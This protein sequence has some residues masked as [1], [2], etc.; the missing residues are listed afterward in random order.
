MIRKHVLVLFAVGAML[1][2]A[3]LEY[4]IAQK[5]RPNWSIKDVTARFKADID[6]R[7]FFGGGTLKPKPDSRILEIYGTF[8]ATTEPRSVAL[9]G[10]F[11]SPGSTPKI[12]K[13]RWGIESMGAYLG[14]ICNHHFV[15]PLL[16]G[17]VKVSFGGEEKFV[18]FASKI[19][20]VGAVKWAVGK[21]TEK[22]PWQ[23]KFYQNPTPLCMAFVVP[24]D[25]L[26]IKSVT[27]H[28]GDATVPVVFPAA[29]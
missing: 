6:G 19:S 10:V 26:K 23:A 29:K 8:S 16:S 2:S 13:D 9:E 17:A 4:G 11:L 5:S 3:F 18:E 15:G 24:E 12:E 21:E 1:T 20:G 27:L 28:F 25:V 7:G 22:D 14:G